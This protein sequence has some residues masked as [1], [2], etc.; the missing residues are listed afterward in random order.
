MI[1]SEPYHL[2]EEM[3]CEA[4]IFLSGEHASFCA[5][6]HGRPVVPPRPGRAAS[7]DGIATRTRD[8]DD[9]PMDPARRWA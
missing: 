1:H 5:Q 8:R 2:N 7:I 9:R 3:A 6:A 4:C